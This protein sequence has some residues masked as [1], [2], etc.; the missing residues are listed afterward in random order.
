MKKLEQLQVN[1]KL[2]K[3]LQLILLS[4]IKNKTFFKT[5]MLLMMKKL[6]LLQVKRKLP[7]TLQLIL[8]GKI[9]KKTFFQ[10]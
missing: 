9:K 4:N 2:P 7:K 5:E 6:G 10:D 8:P 3:T 1:R